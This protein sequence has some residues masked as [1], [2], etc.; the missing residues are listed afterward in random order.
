MKSRDE[1]SAKEEK[2]QSLYVRKSPFDNLE[3][4]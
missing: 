2:Q 3:R 4:K 1:L